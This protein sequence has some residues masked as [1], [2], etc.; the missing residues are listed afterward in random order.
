MDL[1]DR[2]IQNCLRIA[3]LWLVLFAR[4]G[5]TAP[6][7]VD[8]VRPFVGTGGHGHTYPGATVP[9]GFVQLSPDTRVHDWDACSGYHYS[10][11]SLLGFS[12]AHLSGTGCRELGDLLVL[13]LTRSLASGG[14]HLP[15]EAERF[16][17]AFSHDRESARPGYYQVYL[18]TYD[19]L[20]E[21]TATARAGMHRYTFPASG[22]SHLLL[23]LV[24]GLENRPIESVLTI[25]SSTM[26]TGCRRSQGWAKD[27]TV[28][29]AIECSRPFSGWGLELDGQPLP[30]GQKEVHGKQVRAHL[31]YHTTSGQ[32]ILLRVGLSPVSVAGARNNLRS[33]I[34]SWD[35]D[36]IARTARETWNQELS[37]LQIDSPD[38]NFRQTFYTALYHTMTG[39]TLYND[40]DGT[41]RGPD[42]QVH[43]AP[44]FQYYSTFSFWDT[45]RAE[46]PLLTLTEPR[47]VDDFVRS[48]LALYQQSDPHLLPLWP[49]AG[50]DTGSTIGYHAVSV[51]AEAYAKGFRKFDAQLACRAMEDTAMHGRNFQAEYQNRGYVPSVT[52]QQ[53]HAVSR[54]LEFAYD[55]WCISQMARAVGR[56]Q[57]AE[58]FGRRACN[59]TNVFDPVTGFFR[60]KTAAGCFPEP[61]EPKAV[62]FDDFSEANAWQ[63][64][65]AAFHDVSGMNRLYGGNQGFIRKLD[66]FF[67]EDSDVVNPILDESGLVGQ[68]AHGN[69]PC[70]H[71]AYLYALAGAQHKTAQRARQIMLAFYDNTPEGLCGNDDCGQISAW[72]VFSSL[73]FYPLNPASGVYVLG[74]PLAAK[75]TLRLD[76]RYYPGG[77]FKVVAQNVSRQNQYIQSAK[78]NGQ[79][80]GHPWITHDQIARGGTLEL[81]MGLLPNKHSFKNPRAAEDGTSS[82]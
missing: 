57:D 28:F 64:A 4:T 25:E 19:I 43:R 78:L 16:R 55:D 30:Q 38:P 32:Q 3:G 47:R 10:D 35:F 76:P 60:G 2:W 54:T 9:F 69:E 68:Y 11:S 73:G 49:L 20:V 62:S 13:P 45:F 81:E 39:P 12:H 17:A 67:N 56:T 15:L 21:L 14:A 42:Q 31:D 33:E 18:E 59:Y 52:G 22:E 79:L 37:T 75:A 34:N 26:L 27:R 48:L 23:D 53:R 50:G 63:Y 8:E 36:A 74:S 72:Y 82:Q 65:F 77:T 24:H 71:A 66:Q 6:Q 1:P 29:F 5:W 40:A 51:I 58:L 7:P 80:L 46:H 44:G 61:F 41:Y 70:Q